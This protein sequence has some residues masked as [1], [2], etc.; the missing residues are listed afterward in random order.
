MTL[1]QDTSLRAYYDLKKEGKLQPEELRVVWALSEC[2]PMCDFEIA[3][4]TGMT[5]NS[6][7]G[8]RNSLAQ[9]RIVVIRGKKRN[10]HTGKSNIIWGLYNRLF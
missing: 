5:L 6:V 8:R 9:K 3:R 7:N 10:P 4:T 2:G 1:M